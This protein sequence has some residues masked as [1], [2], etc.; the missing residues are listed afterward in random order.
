M[1]QCNIQ[2]VN[3]SKRG[4]A[5]G[6]LSLEN[7]AAPARHDNR[8]RRSRILPFDT[9]ARRGYASAKSKVDPDR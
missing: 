6:G 7:E 9:A 5:K 8:G 3:F 1:M 4:H 2:A